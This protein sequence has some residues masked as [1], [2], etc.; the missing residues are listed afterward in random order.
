MSKIRVLHVVSTLAIS[1]GVMSFIMNYYRNI[2]RE[3]VQFDFIYFVNNG[4]TYEN[5]IKK[6][7]GKSYFLKKPSIRS[8][9]SY[10]RFFKENG[11]VY[12][13]IHLH[14]VYLN[15]F[16]HP[17]AKKY[18]IK[19]R[20]THS[21]NTMYSEN[22]IK[23]IRNKLLC[24]PLK[25]TSNI[26]FAC[27]ED[28]GKF[29]YGQK[30]VNSGNVKIFNN[31]I[32]TEKFRYNSKK[33]NEIRGELCLKDKFVIGHVG[34]FAEQKNHDYLFKVFIAIKEKKADCVLMLLGD[35]PLFEKYKVKASELGIDNCVYFLGSKSNI[36]D[37]YNAMDVFVLPSI[38]EGLGI[39]LIEA[40]C[41]GLTCYVSNTVPN[42]AKISD[43]YYC[44]SLDDK[45]E[46]WA[47]VIIEGIPY[48]KR[49]YH[50]ETD[51]KANFDI[52]SQGKSLEEFY[53]NLRSKK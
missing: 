3:K 42:Q 35:G 43:D 5:E 6:M 28:A 32:D 19:H 40:Q 8:Y 38:F 29:L 22:R 53:L 36:H 47:D 14:E 12:H 46:K 44:M 30:Y 52:L 39:V 15:G 31:A 16:I 1:S 49:L 10:R 9:N 24:I 25:K 45:A 18:G 27:S 34:R 4:N 21:H 50:M 2:D 23:A 51:T 37:Y 20:I 13:I 26:F 17:L 7:G 48:N 41:N 11:H 33:R